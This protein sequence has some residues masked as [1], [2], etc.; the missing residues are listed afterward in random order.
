MNLT[1]VLFLVFIPLGFLSR[2][3]LTGCFLYIETQNLGK[4]QTLPALPAMAA[5]IGVSEIIP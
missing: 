5:L 1:Q 2:N 4:D 3:Y